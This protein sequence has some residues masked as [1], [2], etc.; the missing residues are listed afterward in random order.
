MYILLG[1]LVYVNFW[2]LNL[3]VSIWCLI[4][5]NIRLC[6]AALVV[7]VVNY[8]WPC[9]PSELSK[10]SIGL[11]LPQDQRT[12][13]VAH[14]FPWLFNWWITQNWFHSLSLIEGNLAALNPQDI[15]I[16][17]HLPTHGQVHY[18][19]IVFTQNVLLNACSIHVQRTSLL[20]T[21]NVTLSYDWKVLFFFKI[22]MLKMNSWTLYKM[23]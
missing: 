13:K 7:P 10:S 4:G 16:I 6:G 11:L 23:K 20:K 19:Y 12:F 8:W 5:F 17:K 1:K 15:E 22:S 9:L 3:I 14:Y 2:K 21:L 18:T